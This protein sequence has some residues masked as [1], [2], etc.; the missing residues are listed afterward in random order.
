[1]ILSG[2]E[3]I[4]GRWVEHADE[5]LNINVSDQWEDTTT[6]KSQENPETAEQILTTAE[7]EV[8]IKKPMNKNTPGMDLI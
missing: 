7:V 4:L 1:M 2:N 5:L 6:I 8:A 3:M